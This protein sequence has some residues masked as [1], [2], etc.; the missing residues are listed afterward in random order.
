MGPA[1]RMIHVVEIFTQNAPLGITAALL[2]RP[3]KKQASPQAGHV[4]AAMS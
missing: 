1:Q 3:K 4:V 2:L